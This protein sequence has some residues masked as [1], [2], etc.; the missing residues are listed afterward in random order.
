MS[1]KQLYILIP[2]VIAIL[3]AGVLFTLVFL[4]GSSDEARIP[5]I[6]VI[7]PTDLALVTLGPKLAELGYIEGESVQYYVV[8]DQDHTA[9]FKV[10][11]DANVDLIIATGAPDALLASSQTNTIPIVFMGDQGQ[12]VNEL[13]PLIDQQGGNTNLTGTI[14][15]NP[16]KRRF[17]LLMET[18]PSVKTV[19]FPYDPTKSLSVESLTLTQEAVA[20]YDVTLVTQEF[21]TDQEADEALKSLPE[22]TDAII[23]GL[24]LPTIVRMTQWVE[25][26]L[27]R[28]IPIVV[29]LGQLDDIIFPNGILMGYGGSTDAI[30]DETVELIDQ[31]LQGAKPSHLPIR[32]TDEYLSISLGV[33]D[34]LNIDIPDSILS[35]ATYV[36]REPVTIPTVEA[37]TVAATA[38]VAVGA[39]NAILHSPLGDTTVCISQ[40]CNLVQD[41]N[42]VTFTDKVEADSCA[43]EGLLGICSTSTFNTTYF[44][45][46]E[47]AS[48]QSGCILSGGTWQVGGG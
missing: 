48:L 32:P 25:L 26:S 46:G 36:L 33:A 18:I 43:S 42:I 19:Y 31:I 21:T 29:P 2:I 3:V 7:G 14:S 17:Q 34:A 13:K 9:A 15:T 38:E 35:Q 47:A 8:T 10:M 16:A 5:T 44:Y 12:Y 30:Y 37:E 27:T 23:L 45:S 41:A 22:D 20:N 11:V 28:Q 39:C 1:K 4:D 40:P 24:E 6:G